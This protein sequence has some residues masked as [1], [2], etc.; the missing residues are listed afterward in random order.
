MLEQLN[1]HRAMYNEI[2]LKDIKSKRS[3]IPHVQEYREWV[4]WRSEFR[5][6]FKKPSVKVLD[7]F[8]Q[9]VKEAAES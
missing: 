3:P 2:T 8:K 1:R 7:I 9:P 5:R 6:P 4:Q